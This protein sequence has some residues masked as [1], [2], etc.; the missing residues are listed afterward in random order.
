MKPTQLSPSITHTIMLKFS[1]PLTKNSKQISHLTLVKQIHHKSQ[2]KPKFQWQRPTNFPLSTN[3]AQP[4]NWS[5]DHHKP[6]HI[7]AIIPILS[8][9]TNSTFKL[10]ISP[11]KTIILSIQSNHAQPLIWALKPHTF[12]Q[13]SAPNQ[14]TCSAHH[15]T[16]TSSEITSN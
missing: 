7:S 11:K 9:S 15:S 6:T 8:T 3:N 12:I 14:S 16:Q 4:L 13:P 5:L 10:R 1:I 2:F